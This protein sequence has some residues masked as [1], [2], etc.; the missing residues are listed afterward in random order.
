V[1]ASSDASTDATQQCS[2]DNQGAFTQSLLQSVLVLTALLAVQRWLCPAKLVSLVFAAFSMCYNVLK[3]LVTGS[4]ELLCFFTKVADAVTGDDQHRIRSYSCSSSDA[5][6]DTDSSSIDSISNSNN[7]EADR[8][9]SNSSSSN[10]SRD[11]VLVILVAV[12]VVLMTGTATA[13]AMR[14]AA[15]AVVAQQ[16]QQ[17][18][19]W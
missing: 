1:H 16:Q 13:V 5:D 12:V 3:L 8:N 14:T 17:Q 18:Q 7:E 2:D 10:S 19:R 15:A 9:N 6:S 11:K 4:V